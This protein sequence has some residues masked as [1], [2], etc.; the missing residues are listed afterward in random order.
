ME[1]FLERCVHC[2]KIIRECEC[3]SPEPK[4]ERWFVC[5]ECAKGVGDE[6]EEHEIRE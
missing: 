6:G 4:E 2:K 5:D 3:P 1:H